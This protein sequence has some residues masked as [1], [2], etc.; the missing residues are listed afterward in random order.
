MLE[1]SFE[2]IDSALSTLDISK[3][4]DNIHGIMIHNHHPRGKT[5]QLEIFNTSWRLGRL[6]RDWK[7]ALV[8]P[9]RKSYK[10]TGTSD[11]FR[12]ITLTRVSCKL[13]EIQ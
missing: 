13:M 5:S 3:F 12:S 4:L 8:I 7:F 2:E 9:I 1:F 11:N 10:P 6:S